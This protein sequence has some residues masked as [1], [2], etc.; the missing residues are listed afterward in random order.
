MLGAAQEQW[1]TK[2]LAQERARWSLV[3]Q[4]TLF[5]RVVL[6]TDPNAVYS[7]FWDGYGATRDRVTA[8]LTAPTVRNPIVLSGDVHSFWVNDVKRDFARPDAPTVATEIVTSC[9]ASRNGPE[10]M[11]GPAPAL[12]PHVRFLDNAHAGY[13]LLDMRPE[14]L[15][16]DMRVVA[17][18]TDPNGSCAS[19][20]R[21]EIGRAHVCTPVTNAQLVCRLL[22]DK[23][24][25]NI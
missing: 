19:L 22:L 10:A 18:L 21:Y 20:A 4:Q 8:A 6:P 11:F 2:G 5:S 13:T 12:N 1:L 14:R 25:N 17:D 7:D 23:K 3:T 24:K 16:I 9:L 15:D